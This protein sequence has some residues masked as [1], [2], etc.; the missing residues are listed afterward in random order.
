MMPEIGCRQ[1]RGNMPAL[2]HY[3]VMNVF[4]GSVAVA[5]GALAVSIFTDPR[6]HAAR[7]DFGGTAK[8]TET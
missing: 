1:T 4:W 8:R 6:S 7:A 2:K 5:L 3:T